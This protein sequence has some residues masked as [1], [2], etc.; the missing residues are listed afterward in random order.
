M[1]DILQLLA[2]FESESEKKQ[3]QLIPTLVSSG[4]P[5]LA[6]LREFLR[7]RESSSINLVVG[8]AYSTLYQTPENQEFLKTH[9]PNGLVPL[10][11]EQNI[12][13]Q[14]LE[15]LLLQQDYQAADTLT[16]EKLWELAGEGAMK[17]KWVYFTEVEQFPITDL[18][19]IDLLWWIYSEGKFGYRVQREIWQ[20]L[21]KDFV[22]LWPK[23]NWKNGNKWTKYPNEF[24]WDLSAPVGHLPLTNQ[25]R[26]VR[27]I[28][29]IFRHPVWSETSR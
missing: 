15:H 7:K 1:D 19:T 12:D 28:E 4:E 20:T 3:L 10:K 14:Q 22:K 26:G 5:G 27:V 9:F 17:R 11:S 18:Y 29:A 23:I 2:Q 16:R 25:L 6:A 13:Y 8:K 24:T 21:G